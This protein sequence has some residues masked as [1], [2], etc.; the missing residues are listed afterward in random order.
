MR[1]QHQYFR[2]SN[3]TQRFRV[4]A[5]SNERKKCFQ[6]RLCPVSVVRIASVTQN[7]ANGTDEKN[8]RRKRNIKS[9]LFILC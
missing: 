4:R 8:L 3:Y 5:L 1:N 6:A 2:L 7:T 9:V